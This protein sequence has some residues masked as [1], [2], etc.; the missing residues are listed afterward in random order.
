MKYFFLSF[1]AVVLLVVSLLGLRGDKFS[2]PPIELLPDMD[3][4]DKLKGQRASGFFMDGMGARKP[5][6]GTVPRNADSGVLP[7]EFSEGRDGYYAT[8]I[9]TGKYGNGMPEELGTADATKAKGLINRGK[10]MFGVH[11]G[12]CHGDSGDGKGVVG[13]YFTN[14]K[15]PVTVPD[16]NTFKQATHP[17]G[18][19]FKVV[20]DG[21]GLMGGY[22]HNLPLRDRWAIVAYLRVLQGAN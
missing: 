13:H 5:I 22:K 19:I 6:A 18:Y 10:D 16:L 7:I 9:L 17:D 21:K 11:C 4:Q 12:I 8:G 1:L 2:A 20:S 3:H 15:T 14:A